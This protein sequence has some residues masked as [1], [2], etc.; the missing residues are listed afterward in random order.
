MS[1]LIWNIFLALAWVAVTGS[2]TPGTLLTGFILGYIILGFAHRGE[3]SS[4]YFGK[5][6][7]AVSFALFFAW[8]LF[9]SSLRVAYDVLTPRHHM[10]PGVVAIPLEILSDGEITILAN[11]VS[12]TPGSLSLD[13]SGDRRVLYIHSMYIDGDDVE[14]VRRKIKYFEQ[15]LLEIS[16]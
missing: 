8:E 1:L 2:L 6:F 3:G 12:L 7:K 9:I 13:V 15:L 14:G 5:V 10:R 16:R 11:L 4:R